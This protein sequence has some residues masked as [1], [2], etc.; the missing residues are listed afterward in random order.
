MPQRSWAYSQWMPIRLRNKMLYVLFDS[1]Q[2]DQHAS[3]ESQLPA[4][5]GRVLSGTAPKLTNAARFSI[6]LTTLE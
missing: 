1:N 6:S 3:G 2:G 4:I 5:A